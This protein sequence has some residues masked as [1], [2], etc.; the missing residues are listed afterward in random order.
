MINYQAKFF[1]LSGSLHNKGLQ[2]WIFIYIF[3]EQDEDC[4]NS[5]IQ[6]ENQGQTATRNLLPWFIETPNYKFQVVQKLKSVLD[7]FPSFRVDSD[8]DRLWASNTDCFS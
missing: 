7:S 4:D 5:K 6:S 2:N 1:K 3:I 8:L